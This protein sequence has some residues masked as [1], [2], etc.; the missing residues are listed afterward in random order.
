MRL[1]IQ[2]QG[3]IQVPL[4]IGRLWLTMGEGDRRQEIRGVLLQANPDLNGL[5]G[6][7]R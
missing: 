4:T 3:L 2:Y 5:A 1:P 6:L 7:A